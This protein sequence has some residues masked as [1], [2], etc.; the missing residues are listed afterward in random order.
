MYNSLP[1]HPEI[2]RSV[3]HLAGGDG[4]QPGNKEDFDFYH[5]VGRGGHVDDHHRSGGGSGGAAV[6]IAREPHA[7]VP[8]R[9]TFFFTGT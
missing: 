7:P 2:P 5:G 1:L 6:I 4:N 9:T 8:S 3:L